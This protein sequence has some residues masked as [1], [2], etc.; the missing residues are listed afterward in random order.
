VTNVEIRIQDSARSALARFYKD[1]HDGVE[2]VIDSINLLRNDPNQGTKWGDYR[3]MHVGVYRV[4]FQV[5]DG[6]PVV[7]SIEHVGR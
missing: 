3:R 6:D 7:I 4:L 1:D 5:I 2:Q